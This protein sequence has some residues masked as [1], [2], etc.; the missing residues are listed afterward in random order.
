MST[1]EFDVRAKKQELFDMFQREFEKAHDEGEDSVST[2]FSSISFLLGSFVPV[3][4]ESQ[5]YGPMLG[6]LLDSMTNGLQTGINAV[7]SKDV[8]F[9]K[10]VKT[11]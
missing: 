5:S 3:T 2:F 1:T 11:H 7:G 10:I 9:I 8:S 4:V 6:M